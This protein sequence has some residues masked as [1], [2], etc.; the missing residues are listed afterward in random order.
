MLF[1]VNNLRKKMVRQKFILIFR[2]EFCDKIYEEIIPEDVIKEFAKKEEYEY[3][4]AQ[5]ENNINKKNLNI[6]NHFIRKNYSWPYFKYD[7]HV[8]SDSR[9]GVLRLIG[10]GIRFF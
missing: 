2:C 1:I 6:V 4:T 7:L 5:T 10:V 8:C 3:V 9:L